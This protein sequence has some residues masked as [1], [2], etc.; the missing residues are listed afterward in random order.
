MSYYL[1]LLRVYIEALELHLQLS[2]LFNSSHCKAYRGGS[3]GGGLTVGVV[4]WV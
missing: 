3:S 1:H 2:R 4:A